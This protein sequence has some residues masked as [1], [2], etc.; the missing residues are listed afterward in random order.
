MDPA[1][2]QTTREKGGLAENSK[3][4]VS[5]G[6]NRV[7]L[8]PALDPARGTRR[9]APGAR[10]APGDH[11][12]ARSKTVLAWDGLKYR[13]AAKRTAFLSTRLI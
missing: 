4:S 9:Y 8:A 2:Q 3:V 13:S 6:S 12:S 5:N 11:G 7:P 1:L 10:K